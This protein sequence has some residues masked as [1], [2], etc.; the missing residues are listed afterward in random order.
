V[1]YEHIR[2]QRAAPPEPAAR[3]RTRPPIRATARNDH[4][5]R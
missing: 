4:S 1:V 3:P 5:R 2:N